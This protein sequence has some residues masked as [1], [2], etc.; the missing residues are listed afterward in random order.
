M[1]LPFFQFDRALYL[2]IQHASGR[3]PFLAVEGAQIELGSELLACLFSRTQN[4]QLQVKA[5]CHEPLTLPK[6]P[7]AFWLP[8]ALL[9]LKIS[10]IRH[11]CP[12]KLAVPTRLADGYFFRRS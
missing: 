9:L 8:A 7:E 10:G 6:P 11:S 2:R 3:A 12:P 5:W 4:S 1:R